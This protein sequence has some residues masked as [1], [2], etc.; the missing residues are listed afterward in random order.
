M[1]KVIAGLEEFINYLSANENLVR[2]VGA[3]LIILL[4]LILRQ[5]FVKVVISILKRLTK[6][7][8]SRLDDHLLDVVNPP[9]C[10]SFIVLGI[11]ISIVVLQLPQSTHDFLMNIVRSLL[12]YTVFWAGYRAAG[13]IALLLQKFTEKTETKLDDMI[14]P[15]IKNGIKTIVVALGVVVIV[16]LWGYNVTGLLAGLG[17]GGLAFALAAKDTAANLFGSITIMLDKPFSTGD[18]IKTPHVE[19]TVEEMGFRSTRVRTF[20]QALVTIPNST[21]SNDAIINWSRMGKRR[22]TYRLGLTYATTS[23][24]METCV[25]KIRSMLKEHPQIHP[26]TIFVYFEGFGDSSLNIFLYF[27]TKTTVWEDF[28]RVQEDVNLKIMDIVEQMGLSVAFPSRSIYIE[29]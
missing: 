27:F 28:L 20:A 18:W 14:Y 11:S 8:K 3:M 22:I 9:L 12:A 17:L 29:K 5:V 24:Q 21:M 6:K 7:T 13:A 19:G 2:I 25:E 26:Q 4:S 10:F 1:E 23:K 15:L 16:E